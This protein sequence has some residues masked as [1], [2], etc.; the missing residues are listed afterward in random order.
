MSTNGANSSGQPWV[1]HTAASRAPGR[2]PW[3]VGEYE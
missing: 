3:L 2:S 1:S